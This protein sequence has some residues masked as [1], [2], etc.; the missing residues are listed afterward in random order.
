MGCL[1]SDLCNPIA[2][3]ASLIT[4]CCLQLDTPTTLGCRLLD[5]RFLDLVRSTF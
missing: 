4:Y 5:E 3:P 2:L 1:V